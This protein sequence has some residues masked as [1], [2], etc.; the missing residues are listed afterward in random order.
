MGYYRTESGTCVVTDYP[1]DGWTEIT[2]ADYEF[3]VRP[4]VWEIRRRYLTDESVSAS[5]KKKYLFQSIRYKLT[6]SY[7]EDLTQPFYDPPMTCDELQLEYAKYIGDDDE[8]A[9]V[10]LQAKGLA[11]TY[12]RTFVEGV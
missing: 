7:E 9:S 12:I 3:S 2:E 10:I 8:R 1:R 11:K 6:A 5:D 4:P